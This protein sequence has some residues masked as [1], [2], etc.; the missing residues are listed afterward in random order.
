MR[1]PEMCFEIRDGELDPYYTRLAYVSISR[2]SDD[3]RVYT[4]NAETLDERLATD[5]TKTAAVNFRPPSP[6][7]QTHEAIQA[8]RAN[9]P[10]KATDILQEQGRVYEYANLD[11]RLAAVA[12]DYAARPDRTIIVAPDAADRQE[13]TRL[14]RADLQARGRIAEESHSVPVL[15]EQEF[16]NKKLAANYQPGDEIHY[17][18]GSPSIEG[19]PNNSAVTVLSVDGDK[20]VLT[21]ETR[22]GEQVFYNPA[23]L[24][25]QTSESTIYREETRE[26]AEG[27][28]IS[29]TTA[30]R[31][32]RV[33]SGEFAIVERIGDDDSISARLD[34]GRAV[35]L[36]SDKSRHIDYGYTVENA[37]HLSADRLI[38]TGESSQLAGQREALTKLNPHTREV[39]IYTSDGSNPL[40]QA[41][42]IATD[43]QVAEKVVSIDSG[44][45]T[46]P[47][48]T[49]PKITF[50]GLAL[51][52]SMQTTTR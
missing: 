6:T 7:E 45:G 39:G 28:R 33:R 10:G 3:A 20:N 36:D 52:F 13:L 38:L 29:F 8:F 16:S 2:A 22:E 35:E 30:D 21:V 14:I 26:L 42:G 43:V 19:I 11:S 32:S 15:V 5:I 17:K 9:E 25:R 12:I 34:S 44:L 31:D 51:A 50:R 24:K 4:N 37:Q 27:D 48:L 1:D 49:T 23:K 18:T 41:Q 47:E 40:Q 46:T